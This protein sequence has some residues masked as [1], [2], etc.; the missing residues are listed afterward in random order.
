M[1]GQEKPIVLI[2]GGAGSI[3]RALGAALRRDYRVIGM[4]R[5]G[6]K[7]DFP[8]VSIDLT[9]DESVTQ[10]FRT[11]RKRHGGRIASVIHLAAYFDFTGEEKPLYKT[12]N[13]EGTRRLLQALQGFEVGQFVYSGTILVHEPGRPGD[14]IDED[15]PLAPKWA[16]P[17]SKAAAEAVIRQEHGEIPIVL[18]HLAGLYDERTAVPTLAEQI[19]RVYERD[20][21][22]HLYSGD[23]RVGQ[24][25]LHKADMIDAFRRV[26]DRRKELPPE[27][28]ILI[29]EPDAMGYGE[30]QDAV[31]RLIH[32]EDAWTTLK[33]PKPIAKAG[34]WAQAKL[35]PVIPD[36][37]DR[38][39]KPFTRVT[40]G[41]D[42]R[43]ADA[44]HLI[45]AL[46][47]TTTAIACAVVARPARFL[48]LAFGVSLLVTLFAFGAGVAGM[49]ASWACGAALIV[50][51]LP[52]GRI[53][54]PYAG[55]ERWLV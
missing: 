36:E 41:A 48:N 17:R 49:A 40:L 46:V 22:S 42:G 35:E 19:A 3:G 29:G 55:W 8:L 4:D 12:V 5:E 31:G 18:L 52:R 47:L 26:V 6:Q 43:M 37:I 38:G 32:G 1:P 25:M 2:T 15:R 44:D 13:V 53:V 45:G 10:A 33:I 28:T 54:H 23:T 9:T 11:F 39:E 20:L 16:Y 30:L 27:V 21:Q 51:S 50:L 34:A 24:S 14:R 7:A